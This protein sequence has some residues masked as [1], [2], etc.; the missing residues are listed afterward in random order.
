ML[1]IRD[2][3]KVMVVRHDDARAV[4]EKRGYADIDAKDAWRGWLQL[5]DAQA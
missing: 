4:T 5:R 2:G 1:R 3:A